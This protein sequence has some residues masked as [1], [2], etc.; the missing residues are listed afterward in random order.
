VT[1]QKPIHQVVVTVLG[2]GTMGAGIAAHI[3]ATGATTYLLDIVPA[4]VGADAPRS[5]RSA[6]AEAALKALG[7]SRPP[8]LMSP[9]VLGRLIAG[10]FEDDLAK[11]VAKS[12]LVIEAVVERLDIK[13]SLFAKVASHARPDTILATNTSGIPIGAIA[14]ELPAAAGERFL[15]LHFFNPPR[16]MHLLEVIPWSGTSPAVVQSASE[17]CDRALGKGIVP[18]RDTPNFIGN[19]VGIA[20]ML[21]TFRAA[22]DGNYTVEE[23]DVLNG[24]LQGRPATGSFRLGDL[25]GLDVV[26]H[27]VKNLE[28]NL[29]SSPGA[30]NFDP[31]YELMRV[32]E[33]VRKLIESRRLGDKT[34]AGF[35][36]KTRDA[37]G[38]TQIA[39]L[40]LSTLEYREPRPAVFAEL[41]PLVKLPTG[42]RI[43]RALELEGRAGDFLRAVLLPLFNYAAAL[44]GNISETPQEI[45]DAM[46]WGYG[47]ELG[48][49]EMIDAVTPRRVIELL[50]AASQKPAPALEQLVALGPEARFYSGSAAEPQIWVPGQGTRP[51]ALPEGAIFL[52]QLRTAGTL[53]TN[54]S[55]SLLDLG[56]GIACLEFHS[57][58][59]V[60]DAGVMEILSE[61]PDWLA[62]RGFRGLVL[63]NQ[64]ANFCR[65][66]NLAYV[67]SLIEQKDW[68][69]LEASIAALQ[70]SLMNLRHGPL[71]VVAA[72]LGQA[73]GGGTEA[74]LHC[75]EVQAGADLFQGLVEVGVGVLPAGGGLKEI[76]RRASEWA[77]QAPGGDPYA[78][79][80]RGFEAVVMAKVSG[81]ALEARDNGFLAAT[82]GVTFHKSRVIADAKRRAVALA[83]RG[84]VPPDRN[85]P[86]RVIGERGGA[87]LAL[88][89]QIFGWGGYASEHDQLIGRKVAHVLSGGGGSHEKP[90][91]AQRLLDLEREAFVSLC[92]EPKTFAR[93]D[94]ML[95]NKKPLRN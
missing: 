78:W 56:D 88:G 63:G 31:L 73:L 68:T 74:M 30:A 69:A 11:A 14:R 23:V 22:L 2:S 95:K 10:N 66:A 81:S 48:P 54:P 33:V 61:A 3:A 28:D 24:A 72:P 47:W 50:T 39:S 52:D 35:Y 92:G 7:K 25:V 90:V 70:N 18:C 58:A 80:R 82:D 60:L 94:Y 37:A 84:W 5:Q 43:A 8:A 26:G 19:R 87:N 20:E 42:E 51:R 71:P 86:L 40:D 27:V 15:G 29:S 46:R 59:N 65:G 44:T 55:A 17:F 64:S 79:V 75:A 93:I 41:G 49:F 77:A 16:W 1:L 4:G 67:A 9:S 32:P 45:D 12:D 85:A 76:V 62:S 91:T 57:K 21:L 6:I 36:K 53:R 13:K 38:K 83:V 89:V 34:G